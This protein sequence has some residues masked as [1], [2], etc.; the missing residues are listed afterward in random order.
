ME[1]YAKIS[2]E[3][4]K[5]YVSTLRVTLGRGRL[6]PEFINLGDDPSVSRIQAEIFWNK[7]KSSFI[8]KNLGRN[9][10]ICDKKLLKPGEDQKLFNKCPIKIG[11]HCLYFLLP[12]D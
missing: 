4:F 9:C 3:G 7:E 5:A 6:G 10:I 2:G 12:T 11:K 8:I 1:A